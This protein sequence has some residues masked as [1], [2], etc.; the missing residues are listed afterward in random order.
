[1]A[2]LKVSCYVF[3]LFFERISSY[4]KHIGFPT[5][6]KSTNK[7][8]MDSD[9][10]GPR[11]NSAQPVSPPP[12]PALS[13]LEDHPLCEPDLISSMTAFW[14][15]FTFTDVVV[16]WMTWSMVH[17]ENHIHGVRNKLD[18]TLHVAAKIFISFSLVDM[19]EIK[20]LMLWANTVSCTCHISC[21]IL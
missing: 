14:G 16:T 20:T 13:C 15:F 7:Y 2:E 6:Q 8:W 5:I 11:N 3:L 21:Y 17:W 18:F 19:N 4:E 1:M 9:K 12:P 10:V